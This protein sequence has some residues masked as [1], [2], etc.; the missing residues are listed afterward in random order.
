MAHT[1]LIRNARVIDPTQQIDE[2]TAIAVRDGRIAAVGA[3][4]SASADEV[5]DGSGLIACPGLI[6][7]HVHLRE[8]G[9]EDA[10]TIATG[11]AAAAAG[12]FTAVAC[13][14]NTTPPLDSDVAIEFVQSRAAKEGRVRVYVIGA[15]T[16][17]RA[18]QELAEIGLMAQHGAVAFSDDGD[19]IMDAG[20]CFRAMRYVAQCESLFIQ[21]CEDK[22]LAAGGCMHAGTISTRLGLPGIAAAAEEIMLE[23]DVRLAQQTGVRYHMAHVSTAGAVEIIRRA[24]AAGASVT[25][26]VC[27]HHLLLTDACCE[28]FDTNFKMNPPLRTQSDV[29]ACVAGVRDGTVDCLVTDHA[30]HAAQDKELDFPA[31]PMGIIG[32][33]TALPLFLRALLEPRVLDWRALIERMSSRPAQLLRIPGGTLRVGAP[34]DI[35]LIDPAAEW[36]IDSRRMLSKSRNT[37]FDGWHVRGRAVGT[38]VGGRWSY[39]YQQLT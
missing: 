28:T 25:C 36:T 19:G 2:I 9:R 12:G 21:H 39:R 35:T 7:M 26:E 38:L 10:E 11:T 34:A 20:L 8:P 15:L 16:K 23:R 4:A 29:D 5:V 27:P 18:G 33:E 3:A 30:P 6:D 31:A 32:L 22:T 1:I 24:K 13:M 37:P 17:R 14:P